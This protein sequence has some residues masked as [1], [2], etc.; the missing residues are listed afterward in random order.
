M[1][2][3]DTTAR[4]VPV[5]GLAGGI[6]SGKS[7]AAAEF[8]RLGGLVIDSDQ[9][10]REVMERPETVQL[11]REWWGERVVNADGKPDRRAIADIVFDDP[12]EKSRLE[13]L[14][15]PL[16]ADRRRDMIRDGNRDSA[17]AAIILDSPLLFESHLDRQCQ[18]VVF[19]DADAAQRQV[20]VKQTRGWG[21]AELERREK[22]QMPLAEKRSRADFV[23][24]NRGSLAEFHAELARVFHAVI[25]RSEPR[26]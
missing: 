23:V 20:R 18:F 15:H 4:V 25:A 5:I 19:V 12:S 24:V 7:V 17:V 13:A 26:A 16:I 8:A 2:K 11:L 3:P 1:T 21:V 9:L 6:G 22:Q 10:A 14:I